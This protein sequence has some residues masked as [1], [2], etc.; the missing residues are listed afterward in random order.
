MAVVALGS[1]VL[2]ASHSSCWGTAPNRHG[3]DHAVGTAALSLLNKSPPESRFVFLSSES[4]GRA[5]LRLQHGLRHVGVPAAR[6][7]RTAGLATLVQRAGH[8]SACG[9]G[10]GNWQRAVPAELC[11]RSMVPI[12]EPLVPPGVTTPAFMPVQFH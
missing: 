12:K 5:R 2:A 7:E 8:L 4:P 1:P 9:C 3:A 10:R 6:E 11:G